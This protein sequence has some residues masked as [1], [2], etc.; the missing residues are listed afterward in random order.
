MSKPSRKALITITSYHGVIY[1]DGTKTGLF[2]PEAFHPYE[3][4]TKAGFEV[5]LA[6]QTGTYGVDDLSTTAL[7]CMTTRRREAYSRSPRTSGVVEASLQP[8]AMGR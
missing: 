5:D 2:Y 3:V 1:P 6:S 4:L 8:C 7:L